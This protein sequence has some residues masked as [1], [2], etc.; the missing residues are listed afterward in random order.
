MCGTLIR[1]SLFDIMFVGWDHFNGSGCW[2]FYI[3]FQSHCKTGLTSQNHMFATIEDNISI[4]STPIDAYVVD[5]FHFRQKSSIEN[6]QYKCTKYQI[7]LEVK[8]V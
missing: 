7:Q 5:L 4:V 6:Q 8:L 2:G 3:L 1:I